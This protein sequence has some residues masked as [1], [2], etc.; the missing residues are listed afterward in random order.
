[1]NKK[2]TA[3]LMARGSD[4]IRRLTRANESLGERMEL[5]YAMLRHSGALPVHAG[6]MVGME[7]CTATALEKASRELLAEDLKDQEPL[8]YPGRADGVDPNPNTT[9][10]FISEMRSLGRDVTHASDAALLAKDQ[11]TRLAF[12]HTLFNRL[13]AFQKRLAGLDLRGPQ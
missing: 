13:Q 1:M 4:K 10:A 11:G 7:E 2:E 8:H 6:T 9:D 12:I 5:V 3:L